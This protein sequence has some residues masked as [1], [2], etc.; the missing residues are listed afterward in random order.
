[1]RCAEERVKASCPSIAASLGA[2]SR[3]DAAFFE[4]DAFANGR[5]S[6]RELYS[7]EASFLQPGSGVAIAS[8]KLL[9]ML[10]PRTKLSTL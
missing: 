8:V 9:Y 10:T 6:T 3:K 4:I 5:P 7:G 2:V 1:M